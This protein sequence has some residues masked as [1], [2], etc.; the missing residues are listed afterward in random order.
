MFAAK[1]AILV[2]REETRV[3]SGT[4]YSGLLGEIVSEIKGYH[5]RFPLKEGLSREELRTTIGMTDGAGQKIFAMALRDLEKRGEI[6]AEKETL[7]LA[8]HR[9]QLRGEMG[10]LRERLSSLYLSGG[11]APPTVREVLERFADRKREV[12]SLMEVMIREGA[13]SGSA[14]I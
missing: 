5:E 13:S 11:L 12:T 14:R 7:R 3:L 8:G 1:E 4:V 2:D 10:D 9:V 6:A